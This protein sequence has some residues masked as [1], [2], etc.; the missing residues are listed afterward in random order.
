MSKRSQFSHTNF[1]DA[2]PCIIPA[3]KYNRKIRSAITGPKEDTD[4][5]SRKLQA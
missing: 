3:P 1:I 2:P 5:L 4:I